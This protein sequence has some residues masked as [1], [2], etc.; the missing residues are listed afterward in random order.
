MP[1]GIYKNIDFDFNLGDAWCTINDV[2]WVERFWHHMTSSLKCRHL[3]ND[4]QLSLI[5][6]LRSLDGAAQ[7]RTPIRLFSAESNNWLSPFVYPTTIQR[8]KIGVPLELS[9]SFEMR[10][11]ISGVNF[12]VSLTRNGENN[13]T[14][15][16]ISL[17]S[18]A[19]ANISTNHTYNFDGLTVTHLTNESTNTLQLATPP[20][21]PSKHGHR[22]VISV[23]LSQND[24]SQTL[25]FSTDFL[26]K[27]PLSSSPL[28]P[29]RLHIRSCSGVNRT[30]TSGREF[31][32]RFQRPDCIVCEAV[33][34]P[35]PPQIEVRRVAD[36]PSLGTE[37]THSVFYHRVSYLTSALVFVV[38][39]PAEEYNGEYECVAGN[40][41]SRTQYETRIRF[42][43]EVS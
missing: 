13:D 3:P 40:G 16:A 2:V 9:Y 21:N 37:E 42:K 10:S 41:E 19:Q 30:T 28:R 17:F 7:L 23:R 18:A 39:S 34:W 15:K 8:P 11:I 14:E 20:F 25:E 31:H 27:S 24:F 43:I 1:M 5:L 26:A 36:G 4:D 38:R 12:T 35:T 22:W 6:T 33:G 29:H 32:F